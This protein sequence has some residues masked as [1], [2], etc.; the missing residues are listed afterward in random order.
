MFIYFTVTKDMSEVQYK[1]IV[2][3]GGIAGVTC[4][5]TVSSIFA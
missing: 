3:G 4:A 1:Y 2:I 5:E